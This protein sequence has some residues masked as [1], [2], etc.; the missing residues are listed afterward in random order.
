MRSHTDTSGQSSSHSRSSGTQGS[1]FGLFGGSSS[2]ESR[3]EYSH[4]STYGSTS[5]RVKSHENIAQMLKNF[6]AIKL[7]NSFSYS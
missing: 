2:S 4:Q 3:P 6:N 5:E 7:L 1:F